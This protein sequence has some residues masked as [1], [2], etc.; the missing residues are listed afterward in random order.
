MRHTTRPILAGLTAEGLS[1][2]QDLA[3]ARISNVPLRF[4]NPKWRFTSPGPMPGRA[5][6]EFLRL[7]DAVGEQGDA[8]GV[9]EL[10]KD[11]FRGSSTPSSTSISFARYD[12]EQLMKEAATN[13]PRFIVAFLNG[14]EA[15]AARGD[16][17][18]DIDVVNDVLAENE[19]GYQ[20]IGDTL[21]ATTDTAEDDEPASDHSLV[22]Q[23]PAGEL[24]LKGQPPKANAEQLA[25]QVFLCHSSGDKEQVRTLYKRLAADS[26]KPWLDEEDLIGGQDWDTEIKKAVKKSHVVAVCLSKGSV[27]KTGYLQKEIKVALD[28]ADLRPEGA[29]YIVPVRLEKCEVPERLSHIHYIDLFKAD[30]YDRLLKALSAAKAS[31]S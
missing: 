7:I 15:R 9:Y 21:A 8:K 22:V 6:D 13:A 14:C 16:D 30:G 17:V 18:P 27:N 26:F 24:T 12:L 19:A 10:F 23:V 28:A 20:I 5:I 25:L 31:R 4:Q 29:I 2:P 11:C 1:C 3:A